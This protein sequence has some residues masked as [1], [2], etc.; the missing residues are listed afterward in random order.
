MKRGNPQGKGL[1][2]VLEAWHGIQPHAVAAKSPGRVLVDYFTTLLVLSAEFNFK[3]ARG[4]SYYLYLRGEGWQLSLV[5]PPEWR[6]RT[7]G[8]CLGRCKLLPDMTWSLEVLADLAEEPALRDALAAFHRGFLELL[9]SHQFLEEGLPYY[10]RNLPYYRR[11]LA[12]GLA[13]SLAGSLKLS[14]L[15]DRGVEFWL[16]AAGAKPLLAR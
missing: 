14:R 4:V 13:S 5:S 6:Q 12:A 1:V 11:L 7:P 16:D 3:P 15:G 10:V 9:E 8:P 2:P